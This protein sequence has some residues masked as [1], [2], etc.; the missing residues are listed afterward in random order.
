MDPF[1][2]SYVVKKAASVTFET[3]ALL[4][5]SQETVGTSE[6]TEAIRDS[7]RSKGDFSSLPYEQDCLAIGGGASSV[8]NRRKA[9]CDVRSDSSRPAQRQIRTPLSNVRSYP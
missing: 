5:N 7:P 8:V 3:V 1:R 6:R 2:P 9:P 4:G